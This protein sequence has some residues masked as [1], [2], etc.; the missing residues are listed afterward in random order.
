MVP[1][2]SNS[3][4]LVN[5]FILPTEVS[6]YDQQWQHKGASNAELTPDVSFS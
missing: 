6:L 2:T 1:S 5:E 3:T 4:T